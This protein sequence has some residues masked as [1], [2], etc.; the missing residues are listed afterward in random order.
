M[1]HYKLAYCCALALWSTQVLG[2]DLTTFQNQTR[3]VVPQQPFKATPVCMMDDEASEGS[4]ASCSFF[5]RSGMLDAT[6]HLSI[7]VG[8]EAK[9]DEDE[10]A[11]NPENTIITPVKI[12]GW[13]GTFM[14]KRKPEDGFLGSA[15][16][17]QHPQK[18]YQLLLAVGWQPKDPE[19]ISDKQLKAIAGK[20]AKLYTAQP[21]LLGA[22]GQLETRAGIVGSCLLKNGWC[23]D[24]AD[25]KG[26]NLSAV[27][28]SVGEGCNSGGG[29]WSEQPCDHKGMGGACRT[30]ETIIHG[31]YRM[32]VWYP[33]HFELLPMMKQG[34]QDWIKP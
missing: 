32:T 18:T 3:E 19:A 9:A 22:A 15:L 20:L 27:I 14:T 2:I 26:L 12:E 34:C 23:E 21:D 13:Q 11:G 5:N 17:L 33:T 28:K 25:M 30:D 31:H 1:K 6:V 8:K 16:T 24:F 29:K 10:E 4:G 7:G